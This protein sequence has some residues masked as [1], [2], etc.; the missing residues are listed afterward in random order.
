MLHS[1]PIVVDSAGR[2]PAIFGN[3]S[4]VFSLRFRDSAGSV[5]VGT[6]DDYTGVSEF[7]L[8][9]A[10]VVAALQSNS[11][12]LVLNGSE[13]S[14]TALGNVADDITLAAAG[15]LDTTAGASTTLGA[16]SITDDLTI[17]T[18]HI[19]TSDIAGTVLQATDTTNT[20]TGV[21]AWTN[22]VWSFTTNGAIT[23]LS[24]SPTSADFK[25]AIQSGIFSAIGN[26][27]GT[28]VSGTLTSSSVN[29]T[30][31]T[32]HSEFYNTAGKVGDIVTTSSAT[33]YNT[34][35]DPRLK[36]EFTPFEAAEAWGK[37]NLILAASGKFSFN[38]HPDDVVW[39]MNAHKIIDAGFDIGTEGKG[40]RNLNIGDVYKEATETEPALAVSAAGVDQGKAVPFLIAV[41]DDLRNRL[42]ALES[43]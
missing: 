18:G 43:K 30:A 11:A 6:I 1:N 14:G 9:S 25:N 33:A 28:I 3:D 23:Q 7:S 4:D 10:D 37:F 5:V 26:D 20:K 34:S 42:I 27:N 41:I 13:L 39:G 22:D 35:S 19:I 8:S 12:P 16:T 38:S 36:S 31:A 29:T 32:A 15:S 21:I 40:P 2:W 24:I 17:S